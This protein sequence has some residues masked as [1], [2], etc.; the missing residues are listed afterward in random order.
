M[1]AEV[2]QTT[3]QQ[4]CQGFLLRLGTTVFIPCL[5][6][7]ICTHHQLDRRFGLGLAKIGIKVVVKLW[8]SFNIGSR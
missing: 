1:K 2:K 7:C 3:R 5:R 6:S 4:F 8:E